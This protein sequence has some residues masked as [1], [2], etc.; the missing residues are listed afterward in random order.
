MEFIKINNLSKNYIIKETEP[1]I[2]AALKGL[3]VPKKKTIK[4]VQNVNL[5]VREK[6]IVGLLGGNGAG[7]TTLL[8]LLTGLISPT[9]GSIEVLGY[10]PFKRQNEF[11]RQITLVMGNKNQ[12]WWDLPPTESFNLT[13]KIYEIEY[14]QYKRNL[15]YL[16]NLFH[17]EEVLNTQ[18]RNLS[19]GQRMKCEIINALLHF[20]KVIFLDE[21]TLGLDL[22]S[23]KNIRQFIEDYVD[24]HNA[25]V[26]VTSH[27]MQ[28]I[29]SMADRIVILNRGEKI[30]DSN[31]DEFLKSNQIYKNITVYTREIHSQL[32]EYWANMAIEMQ[33]Y[34]TTYRVDN[35][36][37]NLFLRDIASVNNYIEN[38]VIEEIPADD[39]I[40]EYLRERHHKEVIV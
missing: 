29:T 32:P 6:E 15:D 23:Q 35:K 10:D 2:K 33:E 20:P 8:K 31:L 4:A 38:I 39:I 40:E 16:I 34:K 17:V 3:F 19:L 14:A 22:I 18:V 1:G 13:R 24:H 9:S 27:Y 28:D 25:S 7:K 30:C 5:V 36:F 37:L 11:K 21:P 26:I 12:L